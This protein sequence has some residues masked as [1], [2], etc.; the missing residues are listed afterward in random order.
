M[1]FGHRLSTSLSTPRI[2]DTVA[3]RE[4]PGL[5]DPS[6]PRLNIEMLARSCHWTDADDAGRM[7]VMENPGT[8]GSTLHVDDAIALYERNGHWI[9]GITEW[10]ITSET[11]CSSKAAAHAIVREERLRISREGGGT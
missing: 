8:D 10:G 11:V 6:R 7:W 4:S 1:K 9:V 2:V 5:S 3:R